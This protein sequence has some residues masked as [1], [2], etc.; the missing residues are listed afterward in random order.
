MS[1]K[2]KAFGTKSAFEPSV[3]FTDTEI[4]PTGSTGLQDLRDLQ[5]LR[6]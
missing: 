4:G 5:D 1:F 3:P 2:I 6:G